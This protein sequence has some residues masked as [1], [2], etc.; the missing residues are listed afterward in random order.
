MYHFCIRISIS[1]RTCYFPHKKKSKLNKKQRKKLKNIFSKPQ[2][3][4]ATQLKLVNR[5]IN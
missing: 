2:K 1:L 4:I 3:L 5:P